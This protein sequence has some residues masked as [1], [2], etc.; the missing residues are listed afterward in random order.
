MKVNQT[1]REDRESGERTHDN[2]IGKHFKN[3]PHPLTHR[4]H[5]IRCGVHHHRGAQSGFVRE[6]TALESPCHGTS[7]CQTD[8]CAADCPKA[9]RKREDRAKDLAY[10]TDIDKK[11][12]QGAKDV[13]TCHKRDKLFSELRNALD[14]A[15]NHKTSKHHEQ[16]PHDQ[17]VEIDVCGPKLDGAVERLDTEHRGDVARDGIY[18][19]HVADTETCQQAK[20]A[21]QYRKDYAD[22]L[23]AFFG[24][25]AVS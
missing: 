21:E 8:R 13:C 17:G 3:A 19:T 18:L 5:H 6:N 23:T 4:L 14:A 22:L 11:D 12:N 7:D 20:A 25:E 2:R 1:S 24:T 16:Q 15:D 9:K 10:F